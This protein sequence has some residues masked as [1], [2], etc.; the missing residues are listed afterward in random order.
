MIGCYVNGALPRPRKLIEQ[1]RAYDRNRI[2]EEELEKSFAEATEIVIDTQISNGLSYITDGMLK[3]QDLLRPFTENLKGIR[4]GSLTR[5]FDNNTFYRQ[6]IITGRVESE[7]DVVTGS[8]YVEKLPKNIPWKAIL[9][10]PYTFV[11]LSET[12]SYENATESMF[13][14]AEVIRKEI[15]SLATAGFSYVQ[16]ND[17]ALVYE[18]IASSRKKDELALVKDLL[19]IAVKGTSVKT[20]L[21]TYFGDIAEILPEALDFPVDH[22][23]V[24]L[25]KTDFRKLKECSFEKGVALG[26]VDSRSSLVEEQA[27]LAAIAK[28]IVESIY[29]SQIRDV[30]ICSNCDLEFLPWERAKEKM[31]VASSVAQSLRG[32]FNG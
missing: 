10:A 25:Y 3:W 24:D 12:K 22:L 13:T 27:E 4:L 16:L 26:L 5:W 20:C 29:D 7:K 21:Q 9:P 31:K 19:E 17:P 15:R 23:G 11:H 28:E 8:A 14:F 2:S 32:E 6:P 1:T 30:F 18:P